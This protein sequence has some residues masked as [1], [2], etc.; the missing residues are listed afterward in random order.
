MNPVIQIYLSNSLRYKSR[1]VH[2]DPYEVLK[3]YE[4]TSFFFVSNISALTYKDLAIMKNYIITND[5]VEFDEDDEIYTPSVKPISDICKELNS[6]YSFEKFVV[7]DNPDN[8][9]QVDVFYYLNADPQYFS[10]KTRISGLYSAANSYID[11]IYSN[12][13]TAFIANKLPL[14]TKIEIGYPQAINP[15]LIQHKDIKAFGKTYLCGL[16]CNIYSKYGILLF[17]SI[18][19]LLLSYFLKDGDLFKLAVINQIHTSSYFRTILELHKNP[20][21]SSIIDFAKSLSCGTEN[22]NWLVKELY[23]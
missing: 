22:I 1:R 15:L 19:I 16:P 23:D 10:S 8:L 21:K 11:Y 4:H 3:I 5:I 7:K 14:G 2:R 20:L 6:N 9:Q 13:K 18:N 12:Y 17:E